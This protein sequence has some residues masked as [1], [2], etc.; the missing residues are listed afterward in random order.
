MTNPELLEP[1]DAAVVMVCPDALERFAGMDNAQGFAIASEIALPG[2]GGLNLMDLM[3]V[4]F[5]RITPSRP[6]ADVRGH[7]SPGDFT[8][9]RRS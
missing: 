5:Q 8:L 6:P 1:Q 7:L 2:Q 9:P 4:A 3:C